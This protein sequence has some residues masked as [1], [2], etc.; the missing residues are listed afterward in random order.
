VL[1]ESYCQEEETPAMKTRDIDD[2]DPKFIKRDA[3]WC[4]HKK[5]QIQ[6]EI[7]SGIC[8][9]EDQDYRIKISLGEESWMTGKS[10]GDSKSK[11]YCRWNT[12]IKEEFTSTHQHLS[13]MPYLFIYLMEKDKPICYF[14]D[15]I[16]NYVSGQG[17]H[18]KKGCIPKKEW[19]ALTPDKAVDKI[20]AHMAGLIQFRVHFHQLDEANKTKDHEWKVKL[21]KRAIP[22]LVRAYI[23]Q[24]EKLPACDETG[25][26]D[27]YV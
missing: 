23:Y 19:I 2:E 22:A 17:T 24:A 26:S 8:L 20:P 25:A 15:D 3:E 12:F 4:T 21:S 1:V 14:R 27:P 10:K 9:P 13:T 6:A 11:N 5:Y 16:K 18:G 7:G